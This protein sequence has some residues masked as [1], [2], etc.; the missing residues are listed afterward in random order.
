MEQANEQPSQKREYETP[1]LVRHGDLVEVT[2]SFSN[3]GTVDSA[4]VGTNHK[5]G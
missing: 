2:R 3:M 1:R 5:T 4:G